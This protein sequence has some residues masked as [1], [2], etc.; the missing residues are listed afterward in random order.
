LNPRKSDGGSSSLKAGR[1]ETEEEPVFQPESKGSERLMPQPNNQ[2]E[3]ILC[4]FAFLFYSDLQ[5]VG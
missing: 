3:K 4:Y 5:L 1:L 2:D